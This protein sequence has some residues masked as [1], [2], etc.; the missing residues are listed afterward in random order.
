MAA[1]VHLVFEAVSLRLLRLTG[2]GRR[3]YCAGLWAQLQRLCSIEV[4]RLV[5]NQTRQ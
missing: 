5:Y 4:A 1:A 2:P 3:A